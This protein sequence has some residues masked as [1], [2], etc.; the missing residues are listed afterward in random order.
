MTYYVGGIRMDFS[1]GHNTSWK[2]TG[3]WKIE[4]GTYTSSGKLTG[5]VILKENF[6]GFSKDIIII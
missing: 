3:S 1:P 4:T 5:R 6:N 2:E